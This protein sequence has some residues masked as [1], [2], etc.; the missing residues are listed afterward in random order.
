MS[1]GFW[2]E[3][4][5]HIIMVN[6]QNP[7]GCARVFLYQNI[8]NTNLLLQLNVYVWMI[9]DYY[10]FKT[11]L[12]H[13]TH[14]GKLL[15]LSQRCRKQKW[16]IKHNQGEELNYVSDYNKV[17]IESST[18]HAW[19]ATLDRIFQRFIKGREGTN[20]SCKFM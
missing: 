14:I 12:K 19:S 8:K 15:N 16:I 7:A 5:Q 17:K 20:T 9:M 4:K 3:I 13:Q 11:F 6:T 10:I 1:E 2:K 18:S